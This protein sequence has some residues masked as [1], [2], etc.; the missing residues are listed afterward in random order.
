M[1]CATNTTGPLMESNRLPMYG[2]SVGIPLSGFDPA[3]VV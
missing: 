2:A 3:I 1:E